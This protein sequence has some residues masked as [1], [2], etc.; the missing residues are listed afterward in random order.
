MGKYFFLIADTK[1]KVKRAAGFYKPIPS[2]DKRHYVNVC[3]NLC[4]ILSDT[5]RYHVRQAQQCTGFKDCLHRAKGRAIQL[6]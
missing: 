3:M 1:V 2:G 6:S 5:I 4:R